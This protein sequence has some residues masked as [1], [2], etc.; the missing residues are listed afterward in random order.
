MKGRTKRWSGSTSTPPLDEVGRI[1]CRAPLTGRGAVRSIGN[2][3]WYFWYHDWFC[4]NHP[5]VRVA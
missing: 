5:P 4:A 3:P 1:I 2:T